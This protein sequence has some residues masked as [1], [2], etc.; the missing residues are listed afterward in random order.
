MQRR[1]FSREFKVELRSYSAW[2]A[3]SSG[4]ASRATPM[5]RRLKEL[6]LNQMGG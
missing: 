5:L 4:A 6:Q 3:I 1:K 2:K